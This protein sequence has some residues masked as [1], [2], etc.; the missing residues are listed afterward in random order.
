MLIWEEV[1]F[2]K[3]QQKCQLDSFGY[4]KIEVSYFTT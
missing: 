1:T 2:T 4:T 3:S